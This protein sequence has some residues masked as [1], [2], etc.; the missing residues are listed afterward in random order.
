[1]ANYPDR[2]RHSLGSQIAV[3]GLKLVI[4][5]GIS[6]WMSRYLGPV[7]LGKLSYASALV[8]LLA[9]LGSLGVQGSLSALLCEQKPLPG[10]VL[11]AFLIELIGTVIIALVLLPVAFFSGDHMIATLIAIA[12]LGNLFSS[13]EVF[14]TELLILQRGTLLA[15]IGLLQTLTN[16]LLTSGAILLQAPVLAFGWLQVA[17]SIVRAVFLGL[18]DPCRQSLHQ[19]RQVCLPA[20]K[21]L[22]RRGLPLLI[23]GLS[24]S[25]YMKS[26]QVMLQWLKGSGAV[27][28]YSVAVRMSETLYF[29]PM[30]LANTY[31]SRIGK[32]ISALATA[33]EVKKLYQYSWLLGFGMMLSNIMLLPFMVPIL[34]GPQFH[35]AQQALALSGPAAFAVALGCASS[36]WL[37]LKKLEWVSTARTA[38]GAAANVILNFALIPSFGAAGAAIATSISYFVATFAITMVVNKETRINTLLLLNPF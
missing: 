28:Q 3:L 15:R 14:E 26:D 27:G 36:S 18:L 37:Q 35:Q 13:V 32:A 4:S 7:N 21:Q 8:G 5:V 33:Q 17:Q 34:F 1:M 30:I 22:I 6:G 38:T 16:A 9:P 2:L 29:L 23:A 24:V 10:L 11:T 20:A 25:L 12:V 31:F 19:F